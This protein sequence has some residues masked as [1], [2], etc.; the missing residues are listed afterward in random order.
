MQN[1]N[2]YYDSDNRKYYNQIDTIYQNYSKGIKLFYVSDFYPEN[3][4]NINVGQMIAL[5]GKVE[6]SG[7][8]IRA[9]SE[10]NTEGITY[11][12]SGH[13]D[14]YRWDDAERDFIR[15]LRSA[16][17]IEIES[18]NLLMTFNVEHSYID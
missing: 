5:K 9:Y 15:N 11:K 4:H 6:I 3:L 16:E 8:S 2:R 7:F 17:R 12:A 18:F 14:L 13:G 1:V 10:K